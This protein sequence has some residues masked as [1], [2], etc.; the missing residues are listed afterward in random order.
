MSTYLSAKS[1]VADC[2]V[3]IEY[4]IV[5]VVIPTVCWFICCRSFCGRL[6]L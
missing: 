3:C 6:R 4:C 5:E 1:S 2:Q